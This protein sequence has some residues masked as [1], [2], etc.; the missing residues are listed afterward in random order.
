[1]IDYEKLIVGT[2]TLRII[3]F[4]NSAVVEG[5]QSFGS[6]LCTRTVYTSCQSIGYSADL[7]DDPLS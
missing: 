5:V 2:R 6:T 7:R 3:S 1:M 4:G